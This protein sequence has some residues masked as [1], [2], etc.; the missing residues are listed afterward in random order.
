MMVFMTYSPQGDGNKALNSVGT[1]LRLPVFMT[2]SPQGDGNIWSRRIK[3]QPQVSFHDL[4]PARG[5][6]QVSRKLKIIR[7]RV[8][9]TYSPQGDGNFLNSHA[10]AIA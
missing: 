4:F 2:Y 10:D 5:W 6:K 3:K 9:M 8:F 7:E 1:A